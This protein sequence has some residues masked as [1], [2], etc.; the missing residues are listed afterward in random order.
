MRKKKQIPEP[1][2]AQTKDMRFAG[3]FEVLVPADGRVRPHRIPQQFE[4]LENA[5]AWIHSQ[6]GKAAIA[7]MLS[8]TPA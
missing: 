6:E 8:T 4:T 2:A 7:E 3:T 5:E 1:Y